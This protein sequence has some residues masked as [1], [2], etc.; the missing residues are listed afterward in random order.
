[1]GLIKKI[2]DRFILPVVKRAL[3]E[4]P[5]DAYIERMKIG[6]DVA[7]FGVTVNNATAL[8]FS[9]TYACIRVRSENMASLPK[10]IKE[11]TDKGWVNAIHPVSRLIN[12]KPNK[13]TN[14]SDFWKV[15]FATLD[16]WGNAYAIIERS[17]NGEP[18]ALHQ[19]HP[20]NVDVKILGDSKWFKITGT[21][22]DG[23]YNNEN[24]LHF[25]LLSFDGLKGVNPIEYNASSFAK[26]LAAR[27][28]G[29]EF[30]KKGGN[31]KGVL[32]TDSSMNDT[33][34]AQFTKHFQESSQNYDTPLLEYGVK[35]KQ[36]GISPIAAQ[37]LATEEF[38]VTDIARIFN[39]PPHMIADLTRST[40]SNI[41]QQT[42][43]FAQ[44]SLRPTLKCV[45]TE[46]ESKLFFTAEQEKFSV[47]FDINGLMRG[48]MAAR[49]QWYAQM[50]QNGVYNRNEVRTIEGMPTKEGLD[51]YLY[52]SNMTV[53]GKNDTDEK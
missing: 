42:I 30:Y 39:V 23:L 9:A 15:M 17:G 10:N 1:M 43:Q 27:K 35:Y 37:L 53:V 49:G 38:S 31:I 47:K 21:K 34:F 25:M 51:E 5:L 3:T 4:E 8:R 11:Q 18:I 46:L 40:F 14:V 7:D 45:E 12:S 29:A 48:D 50:I 36:V 26:A 20:A 19:V 6:M 32:E 13:Y 2:S 44:F 33:Q 41:E 16:G 24:M 52:P 28:F 22:R